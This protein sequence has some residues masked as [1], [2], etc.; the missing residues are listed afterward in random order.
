MKIEISKKYETPVFPIQKPE[1]KTKI[2][3]TR[4]VPDVGS[5]IL[6]VL[7]KL[8]GNCRSYGNLVVSNK[9]IPQNVFT[10]HRS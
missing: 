5:F 8:K 2:C 3:T 9:K 1:E 10:F 6:S 7:M 4:S